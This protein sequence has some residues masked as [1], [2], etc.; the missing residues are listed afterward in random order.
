MILVPLIGGASGSGDCFPTVNKV[1]YA[2][3]NAARQHRQR[4]ARWGDLMSKCRFGS[5]LNGSFLNIVLALAAG[6]ALSACTTAEAVLSQPAPETTDRSSKPVPAAHATAAAAAPALPMARE[7]A[8][9]N[10]WMKYEKEG[11]GLS[12]DKRLPLVEK[13]TAEKLKVGR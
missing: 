4:A 2:A 13:C 5:I 10:C 1:Q 3:G 11:R 6:A 12:L 7:K 8:S 9:T